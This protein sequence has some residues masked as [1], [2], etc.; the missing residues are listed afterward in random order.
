M[1]TTISLYIH[2]Y[3]YF[4]FVFIS[5]VPRDMNNYFS[6]SSK[7][8]KMRNT[9]VAY[10]WSKTYKLMAGVANTLPASCAWN[11]PA[12]KRLLYPVCV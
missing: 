7:G 2:I 11:S 10:G 4:F 6:G 8:K 9:A 1:L 5:S 3:I 12:C